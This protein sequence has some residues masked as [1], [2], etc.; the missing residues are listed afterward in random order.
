MNSFEKIIAIYEWSGEFVKVN[1]FYTSEKVVTPESD[2][3][4]LKMK[5]IEEIMSDKSAM[6]KWVTTDDSYFS[7]VKA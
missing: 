2:D 3:L 4:A 5:E 6:S 1:K 7:R